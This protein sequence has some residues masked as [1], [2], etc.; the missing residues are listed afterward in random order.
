MSAGRFS[1]SD[2]VEAWRA[3][4]SPWIDAV[5]A[6]IE[7]TIA[8]DGDGNYRVMAHESVAA[9]RFDAIVFN[10]SLPGESSVEHVLAASPPLPSARGRVLIKTLHPDTWHPA[11][12]VYRARPVH[13]SGDYGTA[14]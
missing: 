3:N 12:I 1:D 2:I 4:A 7:A 5:P 10:F 8:A 14:S 13:G 9:E 11:S 6:L